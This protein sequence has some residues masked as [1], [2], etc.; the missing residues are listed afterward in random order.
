MDGTPPSRLWPPHRRCRGTKT[1][2]RAPNSSTT[3]TTVTSWKS[4]RSVLGS[5]GRS[6]RQCTGARPRRR[7]RLTP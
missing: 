2:T 7:T 3:T 1:T 4:L 5:A 6:S